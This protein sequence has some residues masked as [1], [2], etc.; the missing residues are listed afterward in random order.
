MGASQLSERHGASRAARRNS[1]A[2]GPPLP[3]PWPWPCSR[4]LHVS[5][6][7]ALLAGVRGAY[8][9]VTSAPSPGHLSSLRPGSVCVAT[10]RADALTH[11]CRVPH[12]TCG[13]RSRE[14]APRPPPRS[15]WKGGPEGVHPRARL[16]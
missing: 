9:G 4:L 3:S 6:H 1:G 16:A 15:E 2:P 7:T 13:G 11:G 5:L 10:C 12:V 14:L 8:R